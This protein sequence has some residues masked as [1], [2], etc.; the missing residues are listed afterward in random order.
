[1]EWITIILSSLFTL[2]SPVGI[3]ADQVAEGVIRDRLYQA[4]LVDV[5]IDNT[6]N[7]RLV[8]GRV[9]RVRFA[10]RGISPIPEFRIDI[11]DVETDPIDID[12]PALQDGKFALDEPIQAATHI[13]LKTEDIN[14]LLRSPR[15]QELLNT[16]EFNLPGASDRERNRYR[17]SNPQIAFLPGN[18]IQITVD[19]ADRVLQEEVEALVETGIQVIDGHQLVLLE[20]TIVIDGQSVPQQLINAFTEGIDELLTLKQFDD[21]AIVARVLQFNLQPETLNLVVYVRVDPSS[22]LLEFED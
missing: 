4:D 1:M 20:P 10:G 14:T 5:R 21:W 18:R 13:V 17:L 15:I 8:G 12:L 11:L 3:V 19:L 6:P 22:P 2:I 16:L 7:F 9:D